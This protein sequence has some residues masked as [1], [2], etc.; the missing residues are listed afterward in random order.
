M[1]KENEAMADRA[2]RVVCGGTLGRLLLGRAMQ[3]GRIRDGDVL[4]VGFE[5]QVRGG[6]RL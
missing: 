4:A 3:D 1:L 5:N 2:I 6:D